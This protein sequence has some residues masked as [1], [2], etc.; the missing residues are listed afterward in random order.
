MDDDSTP[1]NPLRH[2]HL[3]QQPS[4]P[5]TTARWWQRRRTGLFLAIAPALIVAACAAVDDGDDTATTDT[6]PADAPSDAPADAAGDETVDD[7]PGTTNEGTDIADGE[8]GDGADGDGDD[9]ANGDDGGAAMDGGPISFASDVAPIV[10]RSCASCLTGSGPGSQHVVMDTAEMVA[11]SSGAMEI[12]AESGF[13]PPWPASDDSVAFQHD[14]SLTDV[15][16]E[17]IAAWH[18]VGAPLD[19][20]PTTP[21][22]PSDRRTV[23]E[24][25]DIVVDADGTYDG[26][27][28]QPDEYRCFVFDP[29]I[30]KLRS[31]IP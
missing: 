15:E 20:E 19:V 10:E 17:T 1:P 23:L 28:N 22:E 4:A 2:P 31:V 9:D 21:I 29:G 3:G 27:L 7:T 25:P 16:R 30:T 18:A 24:D 12:V 14:W 13:M 6:A 8:S 5:S 26:E 11:A